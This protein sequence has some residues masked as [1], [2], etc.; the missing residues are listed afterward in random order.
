MGDI[1]LTQSLAMSNM[2]GGDDKKT[3]GV[4]LEQEYIQ[5]L[6]VIADSL[7]RTRSDVMMEAL[8]NYWQL[9][10]YEP[11]AASELHKLRQEMEARF[12][13]LEKKLQVG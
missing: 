5:K 2:E 11:P 1:G 4:R 9:D 8:I 12:A 10:E 13:E 7:G 3:I 6:D